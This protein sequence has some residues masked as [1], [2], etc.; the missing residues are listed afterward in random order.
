MILSA[1]TT[2][3]PA[4][5]PAAAPVTKP[6]ATALELSG[7]WGLAAGGGTWPVRGSTQDAV[8]TSSS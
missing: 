7:D 2:A 6:V 4:I 5:A 1:L 8:A 3:A